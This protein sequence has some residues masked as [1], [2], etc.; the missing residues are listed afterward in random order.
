VVVLRNQCLQ[1]W[2]VAVARQYTRFAR[3]LGFVF[4]EHLTF[5]DSDLSRSKTY[6]FINYFSLVSFP[7]LIPK[8]HGQYLSVQFINC[9][10]LT[11]IPLTFVSWS[12][13]EWSYQQ[14]LQCGTFYTFDSRMRARRCWSSSDWD[15]LYCTTAPS[16]HT[17]LHTS[18]RRVRHKSVNIASNRLAS[19][20]TNTTI[21][22]R[23]RNNRMT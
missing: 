21:I 4:N 6:Y 17:S 13:A 15:V 20:L 9:N 23:S 8:R 22:D 19:P 1:C 18:D 5:S 16:L 7:I 12:D 2:S 14:Y 11:F 3:N 10:S